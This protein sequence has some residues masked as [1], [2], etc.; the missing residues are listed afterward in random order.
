M[1]KNV[2]TKNIGLKLTSLVLAIT[3]WFFVILSGRSGIVLEIPVMYDNIPPQLEVVDFPRTVNIHVE[4]QE[5]LL[6]SLKQNEI[7]AVIDLRDAKTGRNFYT[8]S[9]ENINLPRT[10]EVTNIDPQTI[11][12]TIEKQF[13]KTVSVQPAIEGLPER[14]FVI[15]EIRVDPEVLILEGPRSIVSKINNVKTEPIDINGLNRDLQYKAKLNLPNSGL[16]ANIQKVDV[17]ILVRQ[18]K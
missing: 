17:N 11:G 7:S 6:K 2:L 13:K 8:L 14:G 1:K 18:I 16:R 5:R 9:P 15:L 10:I 12:L 3:L 4:G